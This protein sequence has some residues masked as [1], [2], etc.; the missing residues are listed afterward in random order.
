MGTDHLLSPLYPNRVLGHT[1]IL[2]ITIMINI[3]NGTGVVPIDTVYISGYIY[4][5]YC[6]GLWACVEYA[7]YTPMLLILCGMVGMAW[8]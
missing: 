5:I 2:I 8:V 7:R 4:C 1:H 6:I 3:L